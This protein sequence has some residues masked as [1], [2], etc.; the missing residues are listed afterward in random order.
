MSYTITASEYLSIGIIPLSTTAWATESVGSIM[1]SAPARGA[2]LVVPGRPGQ[3]ARP[4]VTDARTIT[5]PLTVWG[6]YDWDGN[7]YADP[8][9]GLITNLDHLKTRLVPPMG[10][11]F[12]TVTWHAPTGDRRART[13]PDAGLD[14]EPLGLTSARAVITMTIPSGVF[15]DTLDTVATI[16]DGGTLV[17]SGTAVVTDAVI[18]VTGSGSTLEI[19][20]TTT[21]MKLIYDAAHTGPTFDCGEYTVTGGDAANVVTTGTPMWLPLQPGNNVIN[22]T[23]CTSI[24]VTYRAAWL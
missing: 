17:V 24:D 16:T 15:T 4:R 13:L 9:I 1:S 5:I 6:E 7:P 18:D 12:R 22:L 20:N 23:G 8:R 19:H 11:D 21:G 2:D 3:V 14:V 10:T